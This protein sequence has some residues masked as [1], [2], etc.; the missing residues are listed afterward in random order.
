MTTVLG[1]T[2]TNEK[3]NVVQ[4]QVD[5]PFQ[6]ISG[7]LVFP[8]RTLNMRSTARMVIAEL[9]NTLLLNSATLHPG[10][11]AASLWSKRRREPT[12]GCPKF[13]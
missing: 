12:R 6:L 13:R 2:A 10:R 3:G 4:V 8:G 5:Y 7:G 1:T 11:A 9:A